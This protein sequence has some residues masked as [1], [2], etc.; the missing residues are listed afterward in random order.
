MKIYFKNVP[1]LK[2]SELKQYRTNT[3]KT[4][5]I[6]SDEGIFVLEN[7]KYKKELIN[8]G[9]ISYEKLH[10][11]DFVTD[12]SSIY[13]DNEYKIPYNHYKINSTLESYCLR[14]KAIVKLNLVYVNDDIYDL[15]FETDYHYDDY[16]VKDEM[17][18]FIKLLN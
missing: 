18:S 10:D 5:K 12:T 4:I 11:I 1:Q 13:Y 15:Y 6:L 9:I 16:A 17:E 7:N 3:V 14:N 8:D 2:I